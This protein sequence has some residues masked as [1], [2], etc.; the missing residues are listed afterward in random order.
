MSLDT[1]ASLLL[2]MPL[3]VISGLYSGLVVARITI[4]EELRT[5]VKRVI[6][7]I[8]FIVGDK[9]QPFKGGY[10]LTM[11][12]SEMLA[13]EHN[14]AGHSVLELFKEMSSTLSGRIISAGFSKQYEEWQN[15]C[16]SIRPNMKVI[17]SLRPWL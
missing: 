10:R 17:L 3:G 7:E 4:F 14:Q 16:A 5:E 13:K 15:R 12:A 9:P 1:V 8:D 6:L 2:G 11:V